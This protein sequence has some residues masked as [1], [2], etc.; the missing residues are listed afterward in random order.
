MKT[1][2]EIEKVLN[3]LERNMSRYPGMTYEQGIEEA[4]LWTLGEIG[5]EE[6]DYYPTSR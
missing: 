3:N 4:L 5:N 1:A 6:F 2:E